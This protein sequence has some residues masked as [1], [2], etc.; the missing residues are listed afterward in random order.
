MVLVRLF[1]APFGVLLSLLSA[2]AADDLADKFRLLDERGAGSLASAQEQLPLSVKKAT[3]LPSVQ[4]S[5]DYSGPYLDLAYQT[6]ALYKLP[7]GLFARMID[8]ESGWNPN[9][10]S[11]KGAIGLGQLMPATARALGVN[12]RDPK[13]NLD[14]AARY[15]KQQYDDFRDWRLALAAYNAGPD[16]VRRYGGVPPFLET[17]SYVLAILGEP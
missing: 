16:A 7:R 6:A 12:P 9:A 13:Q 17:Q 2:S 5:G 15:L 4:Y 11:P 3:G 10:V 8:Q 14:G 1:G